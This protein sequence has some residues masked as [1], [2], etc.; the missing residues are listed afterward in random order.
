MGRTPTCMESVEFLRKFTAGLGLAGPFRF[1]STGSLL[2]HYS[3]FCC[4]Q[5]FDNAI[6]NEPLPEHTS[7][8]FKSNPRRCFG[9]GCVGGNPYPE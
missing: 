5:L 3:C 4:G 8:L 2:K 7:F 9:S 1:D 6:E